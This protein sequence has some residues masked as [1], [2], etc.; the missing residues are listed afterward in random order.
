[1]KAALVFILGF[2]FDFSGWSYLI[3]IL[4]SQANT[5]TLKFSQSASDWLQSWAMPDIS[6]QA[7]R[8]KLLHRSMECDVYFVLLRLMDTNLVICKWHLICPIK[9]TWHATCSAASGN[10]WEISW[11]LSVTC[12]FAILHRDWSLKLSWLI[13]C[14]KSGKESEELSQVDCSFAGS[15]PHPLQD[16][17]KRY[18]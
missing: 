14:C 5:V 2:N 6:T 11:S 4:C 7:N 13:K 8:W 9:Q 3:Q 1:M 16:L 12:Y 15:V 18:G 17:A 10:T